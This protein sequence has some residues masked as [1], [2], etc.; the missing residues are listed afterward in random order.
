M[1]TVPV[2]DVTVAKNILKLH[3]ALEEFDDVQQ[4]FSNEEMDDAVSAAAQ[5]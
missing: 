3:D 4:V 2:T 1:N 5:A